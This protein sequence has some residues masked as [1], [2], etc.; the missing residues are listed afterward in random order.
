[1]RLRKNH[2]EL[3]SR[4]L[5]EAQYRGDQQAQAEAQARLSEA[6]SYKVQLENGIQAFDEA[7]PPI[8][9]GTHQY[10]QQPQQYTPQQMQQ[11][12][13]QVINSMDRLSGA[14]RKWLM[15]HPELVVSQEGQ[16]RL[17]AAWYESQ[18]KGI[19]RDS[20]E[21]FDF[22]NDRFGF[23]PSYSGAATNTSQNYVVGGPNVQAQY[24]PPSRP[25]VP[26]TPTVKMSD[27]E[28]AKISGCDLAT[29]RANKQK[30]QEF[31]KQGMY[32][33]R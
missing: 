32:S 17:Q 28:A 20:G 14:E 18:Q 6:T 25:Y 8:E 19:Q 10:S 30:L 16:L 5:V 4:D 29:Y 9:R 2:V 13:Y 21:Y 27:E 23:S 11:Y 15:G 24:N 3:A 1:M 12:A 7:H 33:D 31:K 26:Q 22:F